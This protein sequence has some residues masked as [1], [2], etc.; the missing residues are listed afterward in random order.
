MKTIS[1]VD[2]FN[3]LV[4]NEIYLRYSEPKSQRKAF[5]IL[6][7]ALNCYYRDGFEKVTFK[8]VAREAGLAPPSLR[9][10]FKDLNE[11]QELTI[12]YIHLIAQKLVVEVLNDSENP[13]ESLKK[14]L[15][16]HLN[17][18][19]NFKKHL[20]VWLSFISYCGNKKR[21]RELN[22]RAVLNGA[23]RI[24]ELLARGRKAGV[25]F[26]KND[27]E[28]A[29][30]IQTLILGWL[31]TLATENVESPEAYTQSIIQHCLHVVC[32]Q[33]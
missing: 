5:A 14:Y 4:F 8:S 6:E 33:P 11:I 30:I 26:H 3:H 25:F 21:E 13:L 19:K 10:Y 24:S 1:T 32:L 2:Y 31:T 12:K 9:R 7:A 29:R 27:F 20:C 23:Y 17:W 18:A 28:T 16:A 22:T 15:N